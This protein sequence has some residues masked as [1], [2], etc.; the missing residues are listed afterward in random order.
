VTIKNPTY[1]AA[2]DLK[3]YPVAQMLYI[4]TK[5]GCNPLGYTKVSDADILDTKAVEMDA[6]YKYN[7][8]R[9]SA[10]MINADHVCM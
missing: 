3:R 10:P 6:K 4:P 5:E 8:N 1:P 2:V 7:A 9:V